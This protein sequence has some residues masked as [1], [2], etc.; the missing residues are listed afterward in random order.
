HAVD[1]VHFLI[2]ALDQA[3]DCPAQ[4]GAFLKHAIGFDKV[5]RLDDRHTV[6]IHGVSLPAGDR[7][8]RPELAAVARTTGISPASASAKLNARVN[9][10]WRRP[11][12]RG[13]NKRSPG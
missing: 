8:T 2:F 7:T 9:A 12:H 3:S 6:M 11:C 1:R 10:S 13:N 5:I 4:A